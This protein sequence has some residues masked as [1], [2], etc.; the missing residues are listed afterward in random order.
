MTSLFLLAVSLLAGQEPPYDLVIRGG[1]VIDQ[2]SGLDGVMDVAIAGDKIARVAASIPESDAREIIRVDGF[3][4]TPGLVDIH[5]HVFFGTEPDAAYS[6]GYNSLP[7]DG[8]I[9]RSTHHP[10]RQIQRPELGTLKTGS[11]ADVAVLSLR[12]GDF[13]FVDVEG[14]RLK[15]T[16]KLVCEL[17]LRDGKVV[18]DLNG[19]S[20]PSW[21]SPQP[22]VA[23]VP[24]SSRQRESVRTSA[25]LAGAFGGGGGPRRQELGTVTIEI[26]R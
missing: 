3:I 23:G 13:G 9:L 7:P 22:I 10:A 2:G 26:A 17:T 18:W 20:R 5:T 1:R 6:N 12:T 4:V 21:E 24:P 11:P 14:G 25:S 15:G 8:V 19:I 16:Q